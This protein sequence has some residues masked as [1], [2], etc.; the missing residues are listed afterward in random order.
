[1]QIAKI[2]KSQ[3]ST[4]KHEGQ[5]GRAA[6]EKVRAARSAKQAAGTTTAKCSAHI[7]TFPVLHEDQA[8]HHNGRQHLN[9]E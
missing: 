2:R 6:G 3:S 4:E 5:D 1:V 8:D 9:R 7:G